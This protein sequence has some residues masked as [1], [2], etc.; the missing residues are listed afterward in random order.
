[1][2]SA[3]PA[4]FA[5]RYSVSVTNTDNACGYDNWRIGESS[6]NLTFDVA[7]GA[8]EISGDLRGLAGFYF[9]LLGIGTLKGTVT[10]ANA[11]M[12][13]VGTNSIKKGGCAYFVKAT[14]SL[15]LTG[16]T[17]NGT[18]TYTN[19]TNGA[20]EC[21]I[22]ATCSSQQSVAGNRSPK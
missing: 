5:G 6:Q 14:A 4:D 3:P 15:T 7:Q 21:G 16:N 13:A 17:V 9:A 1:V 12:S 2:N 19:Q 11:S 22:L 18:M 10:G 20:A 8:G